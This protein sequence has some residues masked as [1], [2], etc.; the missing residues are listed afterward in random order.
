[1]RVLRLVGLILVLV[2]TCV[3]LLLLVQDEGATHVVGLFLVLSG[4]TWLV[5]DRSR[6]RGV[7]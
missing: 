4:C 6:R 5:V 3:G 1:V 2:Y 7:S